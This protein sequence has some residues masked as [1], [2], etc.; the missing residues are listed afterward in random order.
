MQFPLTQKTFSDFV[1]KLLG[2]PQHVQGILTGA[3]V[4]DITGVEK[5]MKQ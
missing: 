2:E 4:V 1:R 5:F 3:F